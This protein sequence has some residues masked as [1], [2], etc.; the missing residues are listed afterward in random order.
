[1]PSEAKDIKKTML[2]LGGENKMTQK[3]QKSEIFHKKVTPKNS[4]KS[5]H[6]TPP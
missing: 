5:D 4:Q 2:A 3:T 6:F 1:M